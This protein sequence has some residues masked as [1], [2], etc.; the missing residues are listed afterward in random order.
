VVHESDAALTLLADLHFPSSLPFQPENHDR[1]NHFALPHP[2]ETGRWFSLI[3][4][5][6]TWIGQVISLSY[7]SEGGVV[8][9]RCLSGDSEPLSKFADSHL[10]K[11]L[12]WSR[13]VVESALPSRGPKSS[14][15]ASR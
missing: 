12:V 14:P 6:L 13:V 7:G 11:T 3:W 5:G 15:N 10:Q 8:S 4:A 1:A 2:R 9:L